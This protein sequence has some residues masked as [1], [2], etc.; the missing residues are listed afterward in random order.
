MK[1]IL[2]LTVTAF[3]LLGTCYTIPAF[4]QNSQI[5]LTPEQKAAYEQKVRERPEEY[6]YNPMHVGDKWWYLVYEGQEEPT[7]R[8]F[9]HVLADT[10]INGETCYI[11]SGL[12][13]SEST[14]W[15]KNVNDSVLV[16]DSYNAD[17]NTNTEFLLNEKFAMDSLSDS[18]T[19]Y[20]PLSYQAPLIP[21]Y[22]CMYDEPDYANIFGEIVMNKVM[23]Y[24][25]YDIPMNQ[26]MQ[27]SRKFGPVGM[28]SEGVSFGLVACLIDSVFYGDPSVLD[29]DESTLTPIDEIELR[30]SPNPFISSTT[31]SYDLTKDRLCN[32]IIYNM[33][34]QKVKTLVNNTQKAGK[35]SIV[36]NGTDDNNKSVSSGIYFYNLVTPNKVITQKMVMLK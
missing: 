21:T 4:I 10:L 36:W 33:K 24:F 14:Y 19:V 27:W 6:S 7:V 16:Y 5:T 8:L 13:G 17:S 1:K 34:G 30:N 18:C 9:R 11:V 35:H 3:I 22:L 25:P 20:R 32:L 23:Y 29:L 12:G 31:I 15:I 2:A 26:Y 28:I